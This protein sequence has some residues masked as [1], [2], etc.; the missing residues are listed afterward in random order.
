MAKPTCKALSS[1]WR[2]VMVWRTCCEKTKA[3]LLDL[4]GWVPADLKVDLKVEKPTTFLL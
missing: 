2:L 4:S 1:L 3:L